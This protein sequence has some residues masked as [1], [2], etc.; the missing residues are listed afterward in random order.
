MN[1]NQFTHSY[2]LLPVFALVCSA[3]FAAQPEYDVTELAGLG[4][5]SSS[6]NSINNRGWISG[7]SNLSGDLNAVATL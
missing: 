6:A 5:T 2:S 1:R 7:S 3:A 4:G